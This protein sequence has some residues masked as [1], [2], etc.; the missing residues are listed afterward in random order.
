MK[1]LIVAAAVII[2]N[3]EILCMQRDESKYEYISY[4][5][6]F[7][8][9]KVEQGESNEEAII[10]ELKEELEIDLNL[11]TEDFFM[12]IEH[13]YHDFAITMHAYIC[14]VSSRNFVMKE[15]INYQWLKPENLE[16]LDW[17]EADMPIVNKLMEHMYE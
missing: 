6:E 13:T 7:P 9:G 1:H 10:R 12:S 16:K 2:E 15:H 17:A 4:K 14:K 3:G 5:Y 11:T 8:G